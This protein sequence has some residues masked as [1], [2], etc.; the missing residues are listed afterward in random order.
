MP[1]PVPPPGV[2][3]R[4]EPD[5]FLPRPVVGELVPFELVPVGLV[6][7]GLAPVGLALSELAPFELA[8]SEVVGVLE[9]VGDV[10]LLLLGVPLTG[11]L[12]TGAWLAVGVG[13]AVGS[14]EAFFEAAE[15]LPDG[16]GPWHGL[17]LLR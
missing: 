14:W 13:V 2:V 17:V 8:L 1:P 5:R 15:P 11:E 3:C 4:G 7:V 6:P 9:S 16:V 12:L 10:D